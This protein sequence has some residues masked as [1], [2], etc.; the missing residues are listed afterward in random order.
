MCRFIRH[1]M[2]H[3]QSLNGGRMSDIRQQ[4]APPLPYIF[5]TPKGLLIDLRLFSRYTLCKLPYCIAL[6]TRNQRILIISFFLP[7]KLWKR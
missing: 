1:I 3:Q 5:Q 4:K 7:E 2:T 6:R